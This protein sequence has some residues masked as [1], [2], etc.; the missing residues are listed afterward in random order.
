MK[1]VSTSSSYNNHLRKY[2]H[3]NVE[4][5]EMCSKMGTLP[6]S[7]IALHISAFSFLASAGVITSGFSSIRRSIP[8]SSVGVR[9]PYIPSPTL[10]RETVCRVDAFSIDVVQP[11][12]HREIE[13]NGYSLAVRTTLPLH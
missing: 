8:S 13:H 12:F 10:W 11:A 1:A 5:A 2:L 9:A 4:L 3:Q 6:L 7:V